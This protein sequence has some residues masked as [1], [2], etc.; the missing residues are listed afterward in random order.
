[1]RLLS[2]GDD[3]FP[4]MLEAIEGAHGEILLESYIFAQDETGEHFMAALV[5]AARRGALVRLIVD[6]V[7]TIGRL[8]GGRIAHL[9]QGGVRVMVY[10]PLAPWRRR[11][12]LWRRDHRKLLAVDGRVGFVGGL[13]IANEYDEGRD[14]TRPWRDLHLRIE[15]PAVLE[16]VRLFV[17]TWNAESW[18]VDRLVPQ[19]LRAPRARP[20]TAATG[21]PVQ[22]VGTRFWPR[23]GL[24][25]RSF[26]H[27]VRRSTATVAV[28]NPY[29]VPDRSI[30][31]ALVDAA[32]RGVAVRVVIPGRSD[33]LAVD[34][35]ARAMLGPLLRAGVRIAEW[36][37]G[38]IHEKAAAV[39]GR[40]ATVGSF[41]LDHRSLR[42]NLE[43]TAN[44]FDGPVAVAVQERILSDFSASVEIDAQSLARRPLLA[45]LL[46]WLL[47]RLRAWL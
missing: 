21:A 28:A 45:R 4:A 5:R 43:V 34:L 30:M 33:V 18:P 22:I 37:A 11:S 36:P 27:A 1:V 20:L 32:A 6:G 15:G 9:E 41:N 14:R 26:L 47:Y 19:S 13:N 44:L 38:M 23:G 24:I 2:G 12:G 42:Y 7:G 17:G 16:L 10:R 29:F 25:R 31:R 40:W 8:S 35:A 3:A 39:D 46:S